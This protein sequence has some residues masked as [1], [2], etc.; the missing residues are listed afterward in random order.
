MNIFGFFILWFANVL[1][2]FLGKTFF[3]GD[4]ST[5]KIVSALE[6]LDG[7]YNIFAWVD[8]FVPVDFLMP[9]ALLTAVFYSY[10][11]VNSIVRYLIA[12]FK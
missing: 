7:I 8:V 12:I 6:A 5:D 10:K 1:T 3:S 2:S 9:L 4:F 11:F